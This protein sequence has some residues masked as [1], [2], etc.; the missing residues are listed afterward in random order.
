MSQS[1]KNDR[2]DKKPSTGDRHKPSHQV[3]VKKVF[4]PGLKKLADLHG[5]EVSDEVH[6]AIRE[7]L[8]RHGLWPKR[9]CEE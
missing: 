3:R 1:K 4:V 2:A 9:P 5:G 6:T 7:Y 8:Q